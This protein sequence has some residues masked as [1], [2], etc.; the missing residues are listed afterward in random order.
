V[1]NCKQKQI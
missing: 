1:L